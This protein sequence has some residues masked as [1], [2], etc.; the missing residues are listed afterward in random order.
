MVSIKDVAK[1]AN[2]STATVS[3]VINCQSNTSEA[4]TRAVHQAIKKLGYRITENKQSSQT[5]GVLVSDVAEPFFGQMLKGVE[6]IARKNNKQLLVYNS[7]Y[8]A[9]AE[10]QSIEQLIKHCDYAVVHSKW[11]KDEELQDY[12]RQ[13]PGMVLINRYIES[14]SHRCIALDN[15]HGGFIATQSLLNKGHKRIGYLCSEQNIDDGADRL[16]GHQ[17]A[18]GQA[19]IA[20]DEQYLVTCYP[21]QE[22]GRLGTY[23][24]L[25][26][27]LPLTA[28]VAYNDV[29]A[30]GVL[31]A[32]AE[33]GIKCPENI[34]VV[35]FDDLIVARYL[36]PALSTVRYPV[37][38]MAEQAARL[39]LEAGR[40]KKK[41]ESHILVPTFVERSSTQVEGSIT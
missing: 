31:S 18:L 28:I 15:T 22:G 26:K 34:S 38:V 23:N 4:V 37:A 40:N 19:G 6:G 1:E 39:A 25:A 36:T 30:A 20:F 13:L 32:L 24:L 33:N 17:Q 12:A 3:R 21:S 35:G 10:R 9:E 27:R 7:D 29:M 11:L 14:I 16:K 2:V 5:I 41:S 8:N